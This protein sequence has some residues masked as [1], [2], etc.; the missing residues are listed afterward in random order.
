M[1]VQSAEQSIHTAD[2]TKWKML[3]DNKS[4]RSRWACGCA[5]TLITVACIFKRTQFFQDLTEITNFTKI[6]PVGAGQFRADGYYHA[7]SRFSQFSEP[8]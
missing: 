5:E 7:N 6:P 1:L 4:N 2:A 3:A 8:A